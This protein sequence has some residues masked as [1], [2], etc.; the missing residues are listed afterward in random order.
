MV[1]TS[2]MNRVV[3]GRLV[4]GDQEG[5]ALAYV[6]VQRVVVVLHG[7]GA[8]HLHQLQVVALDAHVERRLDADVADAEAVRLAGLHVVHG[9]AGRVLLVLAVDDEPGGAADP[10]AGVQVLGQHGVVLGVPVAD[11][12]GEVVGGVIEGDGDQV[13]AVHGDD[14][15]PARRALHADAGVVEEAA[16]LVLGLPV[17]RPVGVGLDGAHGARHAVLPRVLP[18]LDPVKRSGWS[19][20]LKT[21]TMML[22]LDVQLMVGPGNMSLMR[23]TFCGVPMIVLVPYVTFHSNQ[24]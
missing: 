22:L 10:F 5:H 8:L 7:V 9:R 4:G 2:L 12:H 1:F 15:V 16:D 23:I 14:A 6:H 13:T 3:G 18:L 17:V 21:L 24:W 19:S 11:E 20:M